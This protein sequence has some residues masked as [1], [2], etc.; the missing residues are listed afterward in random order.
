MS[1]PGIALAVWALFL[2]TLAVVMWAIFLPGAPRWGGDIALSVALPGLA[3]LGTLTI[4]LIA[5]GRRRRRAA[6][7]GTARRLE[8]VPDLSMATPMVAIGLGLILIGTT[9]GPWLELIGLGLLIL[10]LG[11]LVRE[12]RAQRGSRRA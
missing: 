11:G 12:L 4:A 3:T 5:R 8:R 10:G 7:D 6:A 2:G 1:R 9:V